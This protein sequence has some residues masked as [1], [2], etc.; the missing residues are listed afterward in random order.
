LLIV[1]VAIMGHMT[2][3]PEVS[4]SPATIAVAAGRPPRAP[5]GP[6]NPP[7]VMASTYHAGGDVGYG[8]YGNPTWEMFETAIG[9]LEGGSAT[10]YASGMAA[11]AAVLDLVPEGGTV[12]TSPDAYYGTLAML[13]SLRSRQRVILRQVD[14]TDTGTATAALS[15]ADLLWA[16]SPTNPLLRLV[17]LPAVLAAAQ[18]AGVRSVVDNTFNTPVVARPLEMGATVVVHSAT[19]YLAGHSDLLMGVAVTRD[20][21]VAERLVSYRSVH[22]AAPGPFEAWLALRGL[23]TLHVRMERATASAAVLANRL[24]RHPRVAAVH[25]PGCG[26]MVSVVLHGDVA[27]ADRVGETT[28]LW[29]H[30]TSLGGVES[31]L[32]RRRRWPGESHEVPETL[33]RLSVGI[34][35]VEDLWND[36]TAA[37]EG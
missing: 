22:G 27:A 26:A 17:D 24:E 34:E 8:R 28:Q 14:L 16:E 30:A 29:V 32:E 37:L 18:S 15:D 11:V 35:D 9:A 33:V 5:D 3:P 21:A 31:S 2:N 10:S 25:Y 23:R 36:L 13:E 6:M 20:P 7:I 4:L 19:K 1:G 12:V